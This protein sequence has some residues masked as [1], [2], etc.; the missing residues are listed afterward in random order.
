M[1]KLIY[2]FILFAF[3]S[4]IAQPPGEW[5][6]LHGSN[7]TN[8]TG[9]F[10]TQ[11]VPS[12]SNEPPAVYEPC[13]FTDL[14][15][16]FWF[17]GG[18]DNSLGTIYADLWKYDPLTNMWTWMKGPGTSYYPGSYGIKGVPSPSN[19]PSC[20]SYGCSSWV[21]NQGNFWLFGGGPSTYND[22]W[23]YDLATNEWTWMKGPS[24]G[25]PGI[26]GTMGVPDTANFP[27]PR[28]E[29]VASLTDL[30]GDLWMFGGIYSDYNDLWRYN[31][32]SNTWT[33]MKGGNTP[34]Q[35]AVYGVKG[36]ENP[37]NTPGGQSV[38]SSWVDQSGNF[39]FWGGENFTTNADMNTMWRFNPVTNNWAWMGGSQAGNTNPVFGT[40]CV[41][42]SL[43]DPGG[44]FENRACWKDA[45]GN[46]YFWGGGIDALSS[47]RNDLWKYCFATSQWTWLSGSMNLNPAGN[48][49]TIGVPSPA[50][51]PNGRGGSIGWADQNGHL[52]VFGGSPLNYMDPYNDLWVYTLDN[53][54]GACSVLPVAVFTAVHP[55]CPGTCTDFTNLS[56]NGT[57]YVWLFP[58]A[59]P[60]TSTD[61]N[62]TNICYS[63]PGSYDVTLIAT[64]GTGSD[65]LTLSNYMTVYPYPP[66]QGILQSGD[67]LFANS[68][69]VSYQW[70]YNG[71]LI[72]GAT[73]YFYLAMASGD[74]NVVAT[75]ANGCEV[76]AAI[77]DVV[78]EIKSVAGSGSMQLF[79]NPV[80]DKLTIHKSQVTSGTAVEISIY[81]VIG[82]VILNFKPEMADINSDIT[83]D[84]S[85]LPQAM[86]YIEIIS[87]E[88]K[89]RAK[90]VKE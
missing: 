61:V 69:A 48:W 55:I 87:G 31:I 67:T 46:F 36:V 39:W 49:G 16:N 45:A 42:D 71:T 17:F 8:S 77:F 1:K 83:I 59:N 52:Y 20:R 2:L 75:D 65:T 6:W 84:V 7:V 14:N 32:A 76:E 44:R 4:A 28:Y 23:K 21:D 64:N 89:W 68:G 35:F 78:A 81:N 12:P 60:S 66:P 38:Y 62:P 41:A 79:P 82:E 37:L 70:Y 58:G 54:C 18:S 30:N 26:Y 11:G 47:V 50:N 40:Q 80:T 72:N 53:T 86:Y 5:M 90:F 43:N 57:S 88:N 85:S 10:G 34:N 27:D 24:A 9:N 73:N 15:G 56:V 51:I 33:W 74:Y 22:L 13:E 3:Q 63:S 25:S 29:C 19:N